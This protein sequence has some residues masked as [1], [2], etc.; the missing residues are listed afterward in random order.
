MPHR[1]DLDYAQEIISRVAAKSDPVY[2]RKVVEQIVAR[3]EGKAPQGT[4]SQ[5]EEFHSFKALARNCIIRS[6]IDV[7]EVG[8]NVAQLFARAL[9]TSDFPKILSDVATKN[10]QAAYSLL[11]STYEKWTTH[12]TLPDFREAEI[13]SVGFPGTLPEVPENGEYKALQ[14]VEGSETA[15]LK[16]YGGEF[17]ISR[18]VLVNDRVGAFKD[19][20]AA[21]GITAGRTKSR[22]AYAALLASSTLSDGLTVFHADRENLLTAALD[23]EGLAAAVAAL[24]LQ[25]DHS[26]N[27]INIEPKYLIVPPSLEMT[28]WQ[29][30]RATS[31][32]GQS[33]S[34][35]QNIFKDLHGMEPIVAPE[36]EDDTLGGTSTNWFLSADPSVFPVPFRR[37]NLEG[38]EK[39]YVE[40]SVGWHNDKMRFKVRI[41]FAVAATGWRG[42]VK[43]TGAGA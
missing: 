12:E 14:A 34:G 25:Q 41:D 24:R 11:P 21:M 1:R 18:Q 31:L 19:T 20:P 5:T 2:I 15:Q 6:G 42:M 17:G 8:G 13:D 32:P 40:S 38:S 22:L 26:G 3:Q 23:A 30:C 33:N 35:V 9:T 16:T 37:L 43:S 10:L 29:L 36:L 4:Y 7:R 39:P 27:P 28:A